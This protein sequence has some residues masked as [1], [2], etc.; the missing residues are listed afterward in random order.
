ME[1]ILK[2]FGVNWKLLGIQMVNFGILMYFLHRFLYKPV[3]AM[4]DKRQATLAKGLK[5]A[6]DAAQADAQDRATASA[7]VDD[8]VQRVDDARAE[9]EMREE[10]LREAQATRADVEVAAADPTGTAAGAASVRAESEIRDRTPEQV[11]DA[12]A[13]ADEATDAVR[14]PV[15]TAEGEL[16]SKL[17]V[18]VEGEV[19]GSIGPTTKK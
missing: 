12:R 6:A 5:D 4:L 15:A 9:K 13:R 19:G 1:D 16:E 3:F 18:E 7:G 14:H 10:Q 8:E 11:T 2:V 17:D